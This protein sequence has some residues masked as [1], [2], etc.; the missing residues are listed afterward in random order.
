MNTMK[1]S[2]LT[3]MRFFAALTVVFFHYGRETPLN[4]YPLNQ[5]LFAGPIWVNYF[6]VLSGFVMWLTYSKKITTSDYWVARFGRIFPVYTLSILAV[7]AFDPLVNDRTLTLNLALLQAWAPSYILNLPSW[8]LSVEVFFYLLFPIVRNLFVNKSITISA[9]SIGVVW[10][11]SQVVFSWN[12]WSDVQ[13]NPLFHLNSFLLGMLGGMLFFRY[14]WKHNFGLL[15]V[16][17]GMAVGLLLIQ[18]KLFIN[19]M[20]GLLSPVFMLTILCLSKDQG[21]ISKI[22]SNRI[23]ILLG[24]SSYVLYIFQS[25]VHW[26]MDALRDNH[27][28]SNYSFYEYL[29]ILVGFSVFIF[30]CFEKPLRNWIRYGTFGL[31]RSKITLANA[32]N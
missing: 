32:P 31:S 22:L 13:Y 20:A 10:V 8:S 6:F 2:Q 11:A 19:P 28:I 9:I 18:D 27:I 26:G 3:A 16:S 5:I 21:W 23:L 1:I 25:L 14:Q 12:N 4:V 29:A 17:A 15:L 7:F 24:D 30:L